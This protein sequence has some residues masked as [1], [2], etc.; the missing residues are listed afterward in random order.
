MLRCA[1]RY[2]CGLFLLGVTLTSPAFAQEEDNLNE[3]Q[4]QAIKAAVKSVSPSVV[5]IETTGGTEVIVAGPRGSKIRKGTG[6]TSGLVVDKDGYIIT[7]SFNFANKPTSIFVAVPGHEQRYVAKVIAEDETRMLTLLQIK[8]KDL[9]VPKPAATKDVQIGHTALAVGRTLVN[10]A[11]SFPSVSQGIISAKNRVWGKAYQTDAKVS[12]TNYG[13]PLIDLRGNVQGVLVPASP[14][15][16][17]T[18]AGFEWYDSG[19]GFAIPLEDINRVLP[20][21]KKGETLKKGLLG[22]R[23]SGNDQYALEPKVASVMPGSAAEKGGIKP[24]DVIRKLDGHKTRNYAQVKHVLGGKYDFDTVAVVIERDKK[25]IDLGKI[26]LG[27]ASDIVARASLGIL[28]IRDDTATGVEV[29]YVFPN[30][31]AAKAGI[32]E[33][34]R[35]MAIGTPPRLRPVP[36]RDALITAMA[37][38]QPGQ[39]VSLSVKSA[40]G[41]KTRTVKV[42]L[43]ATTGEVPAKLPEKVTAKKAKAP[44]MAGGKKPETGL[45]K[46]RNNAGDHDYYV[47]VPE[48]YDPKIA[49][50]VLVW[51][52]PTGKNTEED[53][54]AIQFWWEDYCEANHLILV[55]PISEG[56]RGWTASEANFVKEA[57]RSVLGEYTIDKQ[58]IVAHGMGMGGQLAYYLGF[59][60]RDLYRGVAPVG[61]GLTTKPKDRA[62]REPL[63]FFIVVGDK[64]PILKSVQDG[65]GKLEEEKYSTVLRELKGKGHQY[66]DIR[67]L[68]TLE[69]LVRWIDSLD[70]I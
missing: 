14:R 53:V 66:F 33:G 57:T 59:S 8:A 58:R 43:T 55:C 45:I 36:N 20:R 35:V 47:Y 54:K 24:G 28:P 34:E 10:D 7:S 48:K 23:M 1:T 9:S 16:D 11:D 61:A 68:D 40:D 63:S 67:T 51:L 52:H 31:A 46:R 41:K 37:T 18:T 29:R 42:T 22:V 3:L 32:K 39:E 19:I 38:T 17:G 30:S 64:D 5:S 21:L 62:P 26:K 49:Y 13:G 70:R 2:L 27:G 6:P 65:K 12:P 15:A 50:G 60:A 25:E 44:P 69:E 56:V 4:E